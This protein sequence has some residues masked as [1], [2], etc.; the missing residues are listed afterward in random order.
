MR[1][2]RKRRIKPNWPPIL[3]TAFVANV[4]AGLFLT[5]VTAIRKLRVEGAEAWDRPRIEAEAQRLRNLPVL[6]MNP[7]QFET[8]VFSHSAVRDADFRRSLFGSASLSITYRKA[9]AVIAGADR[10][11]LDQEGT[12]FRTGAQIS[13]SLPSI[14]VHPSALRP[15]FA[16]AGA[17]PAPHVARLIQS[18]PAKIPTA[19]LVVEVDSEG[20]VCLNRDQAARIDLGGA[21]RLEEKLRALEGLLDTNP[22]LLEEVEE[23]NLVEPT[24]PAVRP[25]KG[26]KP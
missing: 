8:S 15:G 25:R 7:R 19:G 20:A 18:L 12:M 22:N 3:W 17:W 9:I 4:V 14:K 26:G 16:V 11:V 5:P 24:R 13:A 23:L 21:D 2:R 6:P 1:R 10:L